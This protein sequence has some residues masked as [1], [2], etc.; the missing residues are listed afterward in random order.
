ME[1][2]RAEIEPKKKIVLL[3]FL[4]LLLGLLL[5]GGGFLAQLLMGYKAW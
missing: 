3:V 5:Y 2:G 1:G 4:P